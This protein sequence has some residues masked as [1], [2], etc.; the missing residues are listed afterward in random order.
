[1]IN[2]LCDSACVNFFFFNFNFGKKC[3]W[4][5]YYDFIPGLLFY[6]RS[7]GDRRQSFRILRSA[8]YAFHARL[9]SRW[10][11]LSLSLSLSL[12]ISDTISHRCWSQGSFYRDEF[13][14]FLKRFRTVFLHRKIDFFVFVF[15]QEI[16]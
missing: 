16:A 10:V 14:D 9:I 15:M 12:C 8:I 5:L 7:V 6:T 13:T 11:S 4:I 3:P 1:M 2:R